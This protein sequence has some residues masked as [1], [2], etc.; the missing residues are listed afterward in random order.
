MVVAGL[1][2]ALSIF[3]LIRSNIR[4]RNRRQ[5][6]QKDVIF[7]KMLE[8]ED[9]AETLRLLSRHISESQAG[10]L[11]YANETYLNVTDG[12]ISENLG[13]LQ[14][15]DVSMRKERMQLKQIRRKEMLGL[16][17]IDADAAIEK[18]TWFHLGRN[19]CE[20][21]LYSLR[22][23]CDPCQEHIDNSFV[24]LSRERVKEFMPLR[25]TM[26]YLLKRAAD[27]IAGDRFNDAEKVRTQCEEFK[28][29][30]SET[31]KELID[32]MQSSEENITV[33]YV[34]L[35]MLQETQEM[36][37]SLQHLLRAAGHFAEA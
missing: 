26:L 12:F 28:E 31:R 16:R 27:L 21:I 30:L 18:N 33:A 9:K 8:S 11:E 17:R 6:E 15:A 10:F 23:I 2:V 37:S 7:N 32:R 14:K 4:Y 13:K 29:C 25:D 22:R 34:Y 24:P 19:S 36:A 35:N 1:L 3:L 5:D 20:D